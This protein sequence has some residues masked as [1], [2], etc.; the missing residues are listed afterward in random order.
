MCITSALKARKPRDDV[1]RVSRSLKDGTCRGMLPEDS[2]KF[3]EAR[4][5][6]RLLQQEVE[7]RYRAAAYLS[8]ANMPK[9][10]LRVRE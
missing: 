2:I 4:K 3:C 5:E 9:R 7:A 8:R 10:S 6:S 1:V